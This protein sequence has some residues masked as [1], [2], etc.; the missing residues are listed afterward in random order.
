MPFTCPECGRT[1]HHPEDERNSYCGNC[2]KFIGETLTIWVIY[3]NP[4]DF[5]GRFVVRPQRIY[6]GGQVEI[7]PEPTAVVDS[8]ELAR[9]HVNAGRA[10]GD[11]TWFPRQSE[12]DPSI[13]ETWF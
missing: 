13:V 9:W 7:P 3:E 5:P 10:P 8:L 4:S 11:L 6:P 1:S 2:H 12:D